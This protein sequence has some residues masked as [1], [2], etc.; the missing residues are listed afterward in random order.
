M[1]AWWGGLSEAGAYMLV[2][3]AVKAGEERVRHVGY[4]QQRSSRVLMDACMGF[5]TQLVLCW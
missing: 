4:W 2:G 3:L 5:R 1:H